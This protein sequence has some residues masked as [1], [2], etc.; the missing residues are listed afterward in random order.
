[1]F[2]MCFKTHRIQKIYLKI[3][4]FFSSTMKIWGVVLSNLFFIVD[5]KKS[6][7]L[8]IFFGFNGT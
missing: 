3:N 6:L 1:M 7:F 8:N 2:K 4:F 5:E